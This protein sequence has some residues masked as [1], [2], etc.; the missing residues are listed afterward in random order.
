MWIKLQNLPFYLRWPVKVL[1]LAVTFFL[2]CFPDPALFVRH[3]R[4][5][6][7]PNAMIDPD[8]PALAPWF[9]E[10][11]Q[12]LKQP[13]NPKQALRT[14]ERFVNDKVP[15]RFDWETWGAAD[16]LPTLPEVL[17][18]GYEDCDG[19][20]VVAAS[21]LQKLGYKAELVTDF[22]HVWVKTDR[23]ETMSPGK[24]RSVTAT[25]QG[26]SINW[27]AVTQSLPQSL[28]YSVSPFPLV[29]E[30]IFIGVLWGLLLRPGLG[31][32]R[33]AVCL[34]VLFN[35][36]LILRFGGVNWKDPNAAAQLWGLGQMI[37]AL[38]LLR[39]MGHRAFTG[40]L[41]AQTPAETL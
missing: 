40:Q 20:A 16:Y 39:R 32:V 30:L 5:W 33:P 31:W 10:V 4:H 2:I 36:L 14:V 7:D 8:L 38:W 27:K 35:G 41:Q 25:D 34:L 22:A 26:L 12:G 15:Y 13:D 1:V 28:A 21:L 29:R 17:E 19:R 6:Q 11:R 24:H 37:A 23:G 3:I 18:K 9:D